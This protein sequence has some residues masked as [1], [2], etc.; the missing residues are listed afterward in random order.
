M[1]CV[2]G[3]DTHRPAAPWGRQDTLCPSPLRSLRSCDLRPQ[4]GR[5]R[6]LPS[7]QFFSG[8]V[9]QPHVWKE[10]CPGSPTPSAPAQNQ[11]PAGLRGLGW[12][13]LTVP[14]RAGDTRPQ[15][16]RP[17]R[18]PT[19]QGTPACAGPPYLRGPRP[20]VPR[21]PPGAAAGRSTCPGAAGPPGPPAA[22]P[23]LPPHLARASA[24]PRLR[25]WVP[26][27]PSAST[28]FP[29]APPNKGSG[30]DPGGCC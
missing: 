29:L 15:K 23:N 3:G 22:A 9:G 30:G 17:V 4:T 1:P 12:G 21:G 19:P 5:C 11:R 28:R 27:S 6:S 26:A 10:N 13:P 18:G 25:V 14:T 24:P 8:E 16:S 2:W 7:C 20:L